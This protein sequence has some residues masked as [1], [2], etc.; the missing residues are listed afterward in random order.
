MV[1]IS[2]PLASVTYGLGFPKILGLTK[3]HSNPQKENP[4][5]ISLTTRIWEDILALYR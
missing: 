3:I 2:N 5:T 4:N 1:A